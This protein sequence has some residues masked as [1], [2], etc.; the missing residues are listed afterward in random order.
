M[1]AGRYSLGG[2]E[3]G[4]VYKMNLKG[5]REEEGGREGIR[6]KTA[7]GEGSKSVKVP[8]DKE[9]RLLCGMS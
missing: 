2:V 5:R 3:A 4:G 6:G 1:F 9:S 7:I 8:G